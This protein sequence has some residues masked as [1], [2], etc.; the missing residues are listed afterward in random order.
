MHRNYLIFQTEHAG[1][2]RIERVL[3]GARMLTG[4]VFDGSEKHLSPS[5][6]KLPCPSRILL[7][8]QTFLCYNPPLPTPPSPIPCPHL[9][10]LAH[11]WTARRGQ[12]VI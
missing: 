2:V 3:H 8:F 11:V 5:P 10:H 12:G 7:A 9:A 6:H 1:E 4:E